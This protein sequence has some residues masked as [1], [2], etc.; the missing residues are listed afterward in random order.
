MEEE[1]KKLRPFDLRKTAFQAFYYYSP[2]LAYRS[3]TGGDAVGSGW[4]DD[5]KV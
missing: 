4:H 1:G 3:A 2:K 5:W